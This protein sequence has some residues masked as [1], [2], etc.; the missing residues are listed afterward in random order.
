MLS[1]KGR[2]TG[3]EKRSREWKWDSRKR[4]GERETEN[5]GQVE[6]GDE[7]REM[8]VVWSLRVLSSWMR[9]A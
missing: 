6:D 3:A 5:G 1:D 9:V 8:V 2:M 7:R 4:T